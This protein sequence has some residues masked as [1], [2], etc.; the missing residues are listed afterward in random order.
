MEDRIQNT[1][2]PRSE[3]GSRGNLLDPEIRRDIADLNLQYL[4]LALQP[5]LDEDPRFAL[6]QP[7]RRTLAACTADALQRLANCPFSLF[8]LSLPDPQHALQPAAGRVADERQPLAFEP[9]IAARCQA[10]VLLSLSVAR[11]LA[12]SAPLSPRIALGVSADVER[13]LAAMG[14]SELALLSGWSGLI[15]ARWPRHEKFWGMLIGAARSTEPVPLRW[16]HCAGLC[17]L[18][19]GDNAAEPASGAPSRRRGR[20]VRG[21]PSAG[22]PC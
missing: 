5:S 7:V 16:A 20:P 9:V 1:S 15:R 21:W 10:F 14:P 4:E 3:P 22:V 17:L 6:A 11:Q 19:A 12:G 2:G 13:R 8:Q 18:A